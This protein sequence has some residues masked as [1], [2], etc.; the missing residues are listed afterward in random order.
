MGSIR[1]IVSRQGSIS[2]ADVRPSCIGYGPRGIM[3][4][5]RINLLTLAMA[6]ALTSVSSALASTPV[7]TPPP[8]QL[9]PV[10]SEYQELFAEQLGR[11][12]HYELDLVLDADL[13]TLGGTLVLTYPNRT[14]QTL[15]ELPLRLYPNAEYYAEGETSIAS[16]EIDGQAVAPRFD[17]S[18][19]VLFVDLPAPLLPGETL[20]ASIAFT[21]VVPRNS[22]GSYGILNHDVAG[23]RFV[24]ADWYPVVAGRDETGWR[25]EPPTS[26]G[27]PTFS[28]TGLFDVLV[29]VPDGYAVIASGD[30]SILEDGSVRIASGPVREFAMVA[31]TGLTSL[32][33]DMGD[34]EVSV[35][36]APGHAA[37]GERMLD[38]AT[39]ALDYYNAA[40]GPYPFRELD[41]VEVPLALAYGVSWSGILFMNQSQLSLPAESLAAL[42]FTIMHELGHQ[43]WGGTVGANSNDHTWMVEGLT[44]A[45]AVLAHS[46]I[47]GPAAATS[48]LYTWI[49]GPYLNLLD[50]FGDGVADVS[51]FDQPVDSPLS[52]LAYGKGALGFL[53]IRNAIGNDAF[54]QALADYANAFRLG[55]AEPSDLLA[56]FEAASGQNLDALWT[57]WFESAITTRADVE[58]LGPEIVAS[59]PEPA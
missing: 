23:E 35:F 9:A 29:R 4:K 57:Y 28:A 25:L 45:T 49:V 17:E 46:A 55:I 38:L 19:T 1:A 14:G 7:A 27:D 16:I 3:R 50:S 41:F 44:N 52:T 11:L 24:L 58:T 48:S 47:Q 20:N 59:L 32:S 54:L 42:D 39:A 18:G 8:P 21:T 5:L 37:S 2:S 43:W 15:T 34:T 33:K 53:A 56:A 36:V 31:A 13:S 10:T 22:I 40:F 51:I 30:E 26:Q 12:P 6:F